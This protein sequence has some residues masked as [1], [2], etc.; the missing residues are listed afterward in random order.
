MLRPASGALRKTLRSHSGSPD[1]PVVAYLP[2][3]QT[4]RQIGMLAWVLS[5][6]AG[7]AGARARMKAGYRGHARP[8]DLCGF[9][10]GP[11]ATRSPSPG[12]RDKTR[13]IAARRP[14]RASTTW[15]L[16][17]FLAAVQQTAVP[18]A[19]IGGLADGVP[20]PRGSVHQPPGPIGEHRSPTT[21]TSR[22]PTGGIETCCH[23]QRRWWAPPVLR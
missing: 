6:A 23:S 14:P 12:P 13:M 8:A 19:S 22:T 4:L 5:E 20:R 9:A 11:A 21:K 17:P 2:Q 1:C 7:R 15:C 10:A 18:R 16:T 3:C